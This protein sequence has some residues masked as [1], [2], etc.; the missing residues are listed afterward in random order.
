MTEQDGQNSTPSNTNDSMKASGEN[1][2]VLYQNITNCRWIWEQN[3][4]FKDLE[5]KSKT[6]SFN[7]AQQTLD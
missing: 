5:N 1:N 7:E 6:H 3:P 4:A 2:L